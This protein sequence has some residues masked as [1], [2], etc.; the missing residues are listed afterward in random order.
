M[1]LIRLLVLWMHALGFLDGE[2]HTRDHRAE[3]G[4]SSKGI[5][6]PQA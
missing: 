4:A 5:K 3:G 2:P 1:L 6:G